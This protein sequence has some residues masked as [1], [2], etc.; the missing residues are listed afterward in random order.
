MF[1]SDPDF[2]RS[3][4]HALWKWLLCYFPCHVIISNR[5]LQNLQCI[6]KNRVRTST[7]NCSLSAQDFL[8]NSKHTK[9]HAPKAKKV[10]SLKRD[11]KSTL[12]AC[13]IS[14]TG[15]NHNQFRMSSYVIGKQLRIGKTQKQ[16]DSSPPSSRQVYHIIVPEITED[17]FLKR[18][19]ISVAELEILQKLQ[20]SQ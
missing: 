14:H 2:H 19:S 13:F 15:K 17:L 6:T 7:Q 1:F 12:D 3:M 9:W 18:F 11:L 4:E 20:L 16:C 5:K 8:A 10:K